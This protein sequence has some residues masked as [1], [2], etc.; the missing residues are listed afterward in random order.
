MLYIDTC[1]LLAVLIPEA[2]SA[3]AEAFLEQATAP[4]AISSWSITELHSALGLKVRTKALSAS[5]AEAV[6]QGF[7]RSLAPGLLELGL[8][9]QDFRNTN[10]C[11]R[12]WRSSLR[13]GDALHLAIASGRGAT[14]CSLDAPFV[15][16]AQQLGLDAQWLG[17]GEGPGS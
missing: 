16:A 17:A 8:E 10:A 6:L 2:H 12:G 15:A 14:L 3:T 5:Q 7:E 11:L 13:A 1:V 9:S 4:L